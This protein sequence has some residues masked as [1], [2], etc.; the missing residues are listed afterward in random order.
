LASGALDE[1]H[2]VEF[3]ETKGSQE[4]GNL[5]DVRGTLSTP[6]F[7]SPQYIRICARITHKYTLIIGMVHRYIIKGSKL[8]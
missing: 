5:D 8:Y 6:Q 1:V 7:V 4:Y 2:D 3:D